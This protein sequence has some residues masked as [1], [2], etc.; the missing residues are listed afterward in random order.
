MNRNGSPMFWKRTSWWDFIY[1]KMK[2]DT[3]PDKQYRLVVLLLG[4]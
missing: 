1:I 4:E 3:E 2:K